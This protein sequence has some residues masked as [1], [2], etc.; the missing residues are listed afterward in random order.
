MEDRFETAN[1]ILLGLKFPQDSQR[2]LYPDRY[3]GPCSSE[4]V[5]DI[6]GNS[7]YLT[8]TEIKDKL[9]E[10]V[11]K[12]HSDQPFHLLIPSEKMGMG[13]EQVMV[14]LTWDLWKVK[15][16]FAGFI[17]YDQLELNPGLYHLVLVD[18]WAITGQSLCRRVDILN[19]NNPGSQFNISLIT[20]IITQRAVIQLMTFYQSIGIQQIS[21]YTNL[22]RVPE[23]IIEDWDQR[24]K[25]FQAEIEP[26]FHLIFSDLKI[27]HQV[28]CPRHVYEQVLDPAPY[29]IK[30][31]IR[32]VIYP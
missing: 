32:E 9:R 23:I 2:V 14:A 28:C 8:W 16:N 31:F 30:E 11:E 10:Q 18:D 19:Y 6:C 12:F 27:P 5:A 21:F 13:S 26:I 17:T 29:N 7:Y 4:L 24:P 20:A 22:T 25:Q 1:N 3:T 15:E